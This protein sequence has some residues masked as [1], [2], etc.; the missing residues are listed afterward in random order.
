[1]G[2]DRKA[3]EILAGATGVDVTFSGRVSEEALPAYFHAA[4]IVC[5][6]ARRGE[7]F[8]IVLLE[9][10]ASERPIV[11]TRIEGYLELL[12]NAGTARLADVD[13]PAALAHEILLLLSAPELRRTLGARGAVFARD[14]DWSTIAQRLESIYRSARSGRSE[15]GAAGR[16]RTTRR[17]G[18]NDR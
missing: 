1:D 2:P 17:K 6:P 3:L 9:A 12:K 5:S 18:W 16:T 10:M 14:Y 13:D 11:A 15:Q 7:S 8:G 4:E